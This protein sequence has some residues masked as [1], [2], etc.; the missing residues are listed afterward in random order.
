MTDGG[1]YFYAIFDSAT[2]ENNLQDFSDGPR[3]LLTTYNL[4]VEGYLVDKAEISVNRTTSEFQFA[5]E[6]ESTLD[7]NTT[8]DD[9]LLTIGKN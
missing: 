4:T 5:T 8:I 1:F 3:I 9:I 7:E 2:D 6:I